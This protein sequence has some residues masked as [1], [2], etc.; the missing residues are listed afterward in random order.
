MV[1]QVT[2][3]QLDKLEELTDE[4]L[5]AIH[6]ELRRYMTEPKKPFRKAAATKDPL[7]T[8]HQHGLCS[9]LSVEESSL[10]S[11]CI[12]CPRKLKTDTKP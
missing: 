11:R 10:I 9:D 8:C 6:M 7:D 12:I 2:R 3:D 5:S 4:E 1:E